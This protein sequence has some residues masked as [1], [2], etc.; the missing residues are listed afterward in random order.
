MFINPCL[1]DSELHD[2]LFM[3]PEPLA[4]M[5]RSRML[6]EVLA[7]TLRTRI[8]NGELVSGEPMDE[9]L[10]AREFGMERPPVREAIKTLAREGLIDV[11][12]T[13]CR[14]ATPAVDELA[15][16]EALLAHLA[17]GATS[18]K[19]TVDE[20][21]LQQAATGNPAALP[22][23]PAE[24]LLVAALLPVWRRLAL[25]RPRNEAAPSLP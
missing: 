6:H 25:A 12:A 15:F 2:E 21:T 14:V 19:V 20:Q 16:A 8:L 1:I 24:R 11:D 18:L 17:G 23:A 4:E 9:C 22:A 7:D 3:A 5:L 10:L 13:G